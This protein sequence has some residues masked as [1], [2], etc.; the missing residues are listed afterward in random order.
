MQARVE[1]KKKPSTKKRMFIM[2]GL[3]LLLIVVIAGIKALTIYK[4]I[5]GMKPPPPA[6]VSTIKAAY[7]EWQPALTAIGSL[8]AAR[9][10]D[11]ALDIAGLVTKVNVQSGDE[12]KEGQV[13]LQL[14]DSEDVAQLHQLEAAAALAEVTFGRA[15]QQLAVKAI[16]QA[17]YDTAAA[18]L[19]AKQ[20]AVQQ[21]QVNVAKKQLRAPFAGRA[22]IVTINPG[23]FLDSGKMVVTLQQLDP[24]FVDFHLPQ[25]NLG[26]L[27]VGQKVTLT[28]DAF[29]N[30]SFE[31]TLSAI[32][33]KVDSDTRNVQVEAK[34]PNPDRVLTPGMFTNASV[35]VGEQQRYLTLPQTAIVYNPYGETV[36]IVK[37][38]SEFDK[39]Q[40]ALKGSDDKTQ[41]A[42]K[43]AGKDKDAK[44]ADAKPDASKGQPQLPPDTLV[45]QQVFVTTGATRGDQ[46]AITK[47]IDEGAEIVTS[48][49]IKLKSG[50]PIKIDNSVQPANSV[51]P[52]PQEH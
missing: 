15:K 37:K 46:V 52:A 24:V 20:A 48:G 7:S 36:F 30:K 22:G 17:D 16:S 12:V 25:K 18:D 34:V 1:N 40:A 23:A 44:G 38:K 19:K 2:I 35:E 6:T 10:A 47:G 45:V 41:P 8:R 43:D 33:P 42:A 9:G 11:L 28:L 29:A 4:M 27:H 21:Q 32:S 5:S 50:S 3:V 13:L 31:G 14:R 39:A 51:S 26:E 49:Q